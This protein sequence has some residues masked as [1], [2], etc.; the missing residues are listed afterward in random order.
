MSDSK[1]S[2]QAKSAA[3]S[4][5]VRLEADR[6]LGRAGGC[7]GEAV[8]AGLEAVG[9]DVLARLTKRLLQRLA[10]PLWFIGAD[11]KPSSV[12]QRDFDRAAPSYI[13]EPPMRVPNRSMQRR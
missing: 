3:F 13:V 9:D 11:T 8:G 12:L 10:Q 1:A 6:A 2:E 4:R 7:R 5:V